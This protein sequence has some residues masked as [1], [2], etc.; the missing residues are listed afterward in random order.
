MD[1]PDVVGPISG[2]ETIAA[3]S[4]VKSRLR[5]VKLYGFGGWMKR[6]EF[7]E[8]RTADGKM[9]RAAATLV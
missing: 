8:V 9:A 2:I 6:K 1:T 5:L 3:G 4:S 7:A